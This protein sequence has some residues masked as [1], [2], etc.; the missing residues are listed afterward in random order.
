[1]VRILNWHR[2]P[3]AMRSARSL[4]LLALAGCTSMQGEMVTAAVRETGRAEAAAALDGADWWRCR[5]SPVGAV[6][7]R[8]GPS[9]TRWNAYRLSCAGYW[10]AEGANA[11]AAR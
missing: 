2:T 5:A 1:M 9:E 11:P 4:A 3:P 6:M 10:I 8:Y 7:D